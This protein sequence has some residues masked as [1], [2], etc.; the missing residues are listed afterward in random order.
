MWREFLLLLFMD[1]DNIVKATRG[2]RR[3]LNHQTFTSNVV[4]SE[5]CVSSAHC[6]CLFDSVSVTGVCHRCSKQLIGL[7]RLRIYLKIL[8]SFYPLGAL[9]PTLSYIQESLAY[10][11]KQSSFI[12]HQPCLQML[13]MLC[14]ET[15]SLHGERMLHGLR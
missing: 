14:F 9:Y 15:F 1:A 11:E 7:W 3:R 6:C 12:I 2:T 10:E 4:K 13:S 8:W 5:K